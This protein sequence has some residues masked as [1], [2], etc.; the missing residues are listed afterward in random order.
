MEI[1]TLCRFCLR[2][3]LGADSDQYTYEALR[4]FLMGAIRR[5]FHPGCKFEV[6]LCLV[7]GVDVFGCH[8]GDR[9]RTTQSANI[10]YAI[11]RIS[12]LEKKDCCNKVESL[13][14]VTCLLYTSRWV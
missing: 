7:G 9:G 4:L 13:V 3:F 2:H 11:E 6:M 1:Y 10:E 5:A 12:K 8:R 14:I